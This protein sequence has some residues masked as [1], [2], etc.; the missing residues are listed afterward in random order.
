[1]F[2]SGRV[3]SLLTTAAVIG[4][5]FVRGPIAQAQ[6]K[7]KDKPIQSDTTGLILKAIVKT[8]DAR[9]LDAPGGKPLASGGEPE[10]FTIFTRLYCA[11]GV[12]KE[13][14]GTDD[15]YRVGDLDNNPLGW[16]KASDVVDWDTRY[17]LTPKPNTKFVV[18]TKKKSG[19]DAPKTDEDLTKMDVLAERSGT[20]ADQMAMAPI[21]GKPRDSRDP[22]YEIAFMVAKS[23]TA[24]SRTAR[25]KAVGKDL[26]LEIMFAVDTTL[27]MQPLL[28]GTKEIVRQVALALAKHP[29]LEGKVRFGLVEYQDEHPKVMDPKFAN[30]PKLVPARMVS[31]LNADMDAFQKALAPLRQTDIPNGD[32]PEDV[33]AGLKMAID[34]AGWEKFSSKHIVVIGDASAQLNEGAKRN[35]KNSTNQSI[36][37][38]IALGRN[39]AGAEGEKQLAQITFHS[40]LAKGDDAS[41]RA[42]AQEHFK[43]IAANNNEVK[44]LFHLVEDPNSAPE[45]DKAIKEVVKVLNE[46]FLEIAKNSKDPSKLKDDEARG[47]VAQSV[48]RILKTLDTKGNEVVFRGYGAERNEKGEQVALRKVF[49]TKTQL[50]RLV[51]RLDYL[52]KELESLVDPEERKDVTG[53]LHVIQSAAASTTT[54]QN[55][56][57]DNKLAGIIS[58]LPLRTEALQVTSKQLSGFTEKQYRDWLN[59]LKESRN[60]ADDLIRR[61]QTQWQVIER[62]NGKK[63]S[64]N[65]FLL[66]QLP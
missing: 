18:Y 49:V 7:K 50:E 43:K 64:M 40:V 3:V 66:S 36:E 54:G 45:R 21:L 26:K 46:G 29:D 19:D 33:L 28:D 17:V 23:F 4:L 39:K 62:P 58:E 5:M 60:I 6:S 20:P 52:N 41:D 31:K 10:P 14:K 48:W 47:P 2:H 12:V 16:I 8:S 27:S 32:T 53:I 25:P 65:F 9:L 1:M 24:A 37:G 15:Y 44:G 38:I 30:H 22:A 13:T 57:P 42:R 63:E 56:K 35:P 11:E 34:E 51:A 59:K 61:P 55:V